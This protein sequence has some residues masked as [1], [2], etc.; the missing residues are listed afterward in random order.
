MRFWIY[1]K[2]TKRILGPYSLER[3]KS[4]PGLLSAETKVAPEGASRSQDWRKAKDVPVLNQILQAIGTAENPEI[5]EGPSEGV[6]P[7]PPL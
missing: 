2:R 3:L 5:V 6:K 4:M 1:D 7:P